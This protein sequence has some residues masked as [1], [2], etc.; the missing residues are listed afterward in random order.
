MWYNY[1]R[2]KERERKTKMMNTKNRT[3]KEIKPMIKKDVD[4]FITELLDKYPEIARTS[5]EDYVRDEA[6]RAIREITDYG[7]VLTNK[8]RWC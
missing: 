3:Q 2:K 6:K 5:L 8:E 4:A 7:R 1:Y